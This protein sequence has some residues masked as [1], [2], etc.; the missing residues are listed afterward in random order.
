[1]RGRVSVLFSFLFVIMVSLAFSMPVEAGYKQISNYNFTV[2]PRSF[3]TPSIYLEGEYATLH[4]PSYAA[5][6][7]TFTNGSILF[8]NTT[9]TFYIPDSAN[10]PVEFTVPLYQSHFT[11]PDGFSYKPADTFNFV[12][13]FDATT[14]KH[15]SSSSIGSYGFDITAVSLCFSG[16][17]LFFT[18]T[19]GTG[20]GWFL[21]ASVST[22]YF[23]S[24]YLNGLAFKVYGH[25]NASV[26]NGFY[27]CFSTVTM[28]F[29]YFNISTFMSDNASSDDIENQTQEL[30][31]GYDNSGMNSDN[32]ALSGSLSE[33]NDLEKDASDQS[34]TRIDAAEFISPANGPPQMLAA[35]TLSSSF[36]Q[37]LFINIGDWSYL[38][39]ISLA[40]AFG[41]ML[42]GWWKYRK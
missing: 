12:I 14:V 26:S 10:V 33:W 1:M 3:N 40:F 15:Q 24:D 22:G 34:V 37:T 27:Y 41:L 30:T 18:R 36:L 39:L 20:T 16:H 35:I 29:S 8:T 38:I 7:G 19:S 31:K 4:Y 13:N 17:E 6:A 11:L 23:T 32:I 25:F 42:V 28:N 5:T 2:T 9:D 21:R